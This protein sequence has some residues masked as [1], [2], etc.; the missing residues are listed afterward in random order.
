MQSWLKRV[1]EETF[2]WPKGEF[3]HALMH[4]EQGF[5]SKRFVKCLWG[6]AHALLGFMFHNMLIN[7]FLNLSLLYFAALTR[8]FSV[9]LPLSARWTWVFLDYKRRRERKKTKT[10]FTTSEKWTIFISPQNKQQDGAN[11]A[12]PFVQRAQLFGW[13]RGKQLT[14]FQLLETHWRGLNVEVSLKPKWKVLIH[15]QEFRH[16]TGPFFKVMVALWQC[17]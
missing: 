15:F 6:E 12:K 3:C 4:C 13:M 7:V 10:H 2:S 16:P 14:H 5:S 1:S 17:F 11:K 9:W 8:T